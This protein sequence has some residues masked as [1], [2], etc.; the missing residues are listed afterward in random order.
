MQAEK[1]SATF[2]KG[3]LSIFFSDNHFQRGRLNG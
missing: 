2:L 3:V 1:K